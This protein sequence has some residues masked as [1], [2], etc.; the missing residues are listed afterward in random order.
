MRS[1]VQRVELRR[2]AWLTLALLLP[3][4]PARAAVRFDMSASTAASG[5]ASLGLTVGTGANRY[6]IVA[7]VMPA[8][9]QLA[10]GAQ[11][12]GRSMGPIGSAEA[13]GCHV[14]VWGLP[15][16]AGGTGVATA[17]VSPAT[18]PIILAAASY[19]GVHQTLP[20]DDTSA[21]RMGSTAAAQGTIYNSD[22]LGFAA[23]CAGGSMIAATPRAGQ[24][25]RWNRATGTLLSAGSDVTG[26]TADW[27]LSAS[28]ALSWAVASFPLRAAPGSS[29]PPPDAAS[30]VADAALP[31]APDAGARDVGA[32]PDATIAD[33]GAAVDGATVP[34]AGAAAARDGQVIAAPLPTDGDE[35]PDAAP[36]VLNLVV[37]TGC[38]AAGASPPVGPGA[39]ALA[40]VALLVLVARRRPR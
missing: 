11:F 14:E 3:S 13:G 9:A 5:S 33:D 31:P 40:G 35:T 8:S 4:A 39:L 25:S 23:L 34:D 18:A 27:Q 24:G 22:G 6:V 19:D 7:L 36:R 17:A 2:L 37:S 15:A 38:R 16:P 26:G 20:T 21:Q 28:G 1:Y 32:G 30:T 12:G 10:A 29:P